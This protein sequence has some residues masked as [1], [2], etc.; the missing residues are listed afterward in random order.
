MWCSAL[1]AYIYVKLN[2]LDHTLPWTLI[3]PNDF[4]DKSNILEFKNCILD[5]E[6]I[7]KCESFIKNMKI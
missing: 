7:I 2:F 3:K 4:S 5:K 6:I 1:V